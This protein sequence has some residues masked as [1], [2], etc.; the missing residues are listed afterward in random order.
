MTSSRHTGWF[1]VTVNYKHSLKNIH[2]LLTDM[3]LYANFLWGLY[4]LI[5]GF[6]K[7]H[8]NGWKKIPISCIPLNKGNVKSRS[9]SQKLPNKVQSI[10]IQG[11]TEFNCSSFITLIKGCQNDVNNILEFG[12]INGQPL[13][14]KH[15]GIYTVWWFSH[16][17]LDR[18]IMLLQHVY[19]GLR[20]IIILS[21]YLY[22]SL[23][24]LYT[25][26]FTNIG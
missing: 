3:F 4:I 20:I 23:R 16:Q 6:L 1:L 25:L 11:G 15:L 21:N 9:T 24:L 17:F 7:R 10:N 8:N 12:D 5:F 19:I 22:T 13:E 2:I 14:G 26:L 18:I